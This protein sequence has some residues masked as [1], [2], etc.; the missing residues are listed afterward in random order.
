MKES[1]PVVARYYVWVITQL[2][3][4]SWPGKSW[5]PALSLYGNKPL[6]QVISLFE[7]LIGYRLP[8]APSISGLSQKQVL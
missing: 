4:Q 5:F 8:V 1:L 3:H 7:F 6:S 2:D